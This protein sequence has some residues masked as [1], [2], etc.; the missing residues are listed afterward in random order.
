MCFKQTAPKA[1]APN[2]PWG[3]SFFKNQ[4]ANRPCKSTC[5][6]YTTGHE[7]MTQ[8]LSDCFKP[9]ESSRLEKKTV[10]ETERETEC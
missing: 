9:S 4:S 2:T 6:S 5:R 10:I 3:S 1:P 7:L 8:T